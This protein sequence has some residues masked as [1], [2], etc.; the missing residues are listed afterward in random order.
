MQPRDLLDHVLLDLEVETV[1]RRGD[2]EFIARARKRQLQA[3]EQHRDLFSREP[4]AEDLARAARAQPDRLALRQGRNRFAYR[5][6]HAA[7]RNT[8]AVESETALDSPPITPPSASGFFVSAISSTSGVNS[9]SCPLSNLR[10]S[11][12]RARRTITSPSIAS[13][14]KACSGCPSSSITKLVMSTIA[15]I[16]RIPQRSNRRTIQSGVRAF[17]LT[18]RM[19]RPQ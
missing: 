5:A 14:S 9:T 7:S 11:P 2:R 12:L 8:S 10:R 3:L 18:A 19:T 16:E 4:H 6:R 15:E 17:T 1:R 13:L